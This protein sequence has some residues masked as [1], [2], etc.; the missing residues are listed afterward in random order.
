[1][2]VPHERAF[3]LM[4]DSIECSLGSL[5]VFLPSFSVLAVQNGHCACDVVCRK[6]LSY[7]LAFEWAQHHS[8]QRLWI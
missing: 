8:K 4:A 5:L 2:P 1:M 6:L 7:L 3:V